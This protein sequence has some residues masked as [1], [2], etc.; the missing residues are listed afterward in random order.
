MECASAWEDINSSLETLGHYTS[1]LA[2]AEYVNHT[3]GEA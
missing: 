3:K 1:A 2:F